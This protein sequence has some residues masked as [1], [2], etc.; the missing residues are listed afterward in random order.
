[1]E[2]KLVVQHEALP[3]QTANKQQ[4]SLMLKKKKK[5]RVCLNYEICC[6][7]LFLS[8]TLLI[9]AQLNENLSRTILCLWFRML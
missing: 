2:I 9:D 3:L 7:L 6:E 1:M 4:K 5:D 8:R